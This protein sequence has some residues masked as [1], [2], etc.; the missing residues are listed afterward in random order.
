MEGTLR[1]VGDCLYTYTR[2]LTGYGGFVTGSLLVLPGSA[3]VVDTLCS[4][5]DMEAFIPLIGERPVT[6]VYTHADW[7]HCLGTGALNPIR[8]IAHEL[9]GKRLSERGDDMLAEIERDNPDLVSDASI[10]LPGTTFQDGLTF[11]LM[12]G[13]SS[14]RD[15]GDLNERDREDNDRDDCVSGGPHGSDKVVVEL[16]HLPGHT[17][18]STVCWIPQLGVLIAGDVVEDPFPSVSEP[19][20]TGLWADGLEQWERS[21]ST[22]IPGHGAVSGPELLARNVRYLRGLMGAARRNTPYPWLTPDVSL[23]YLDP[24]TAQIVSKMPASEQAFYRDV[25]KENVRRVISVL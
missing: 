4:P 9:T 11:E 8:V 23:E 21:A 16:V 13:P 1:S 5:R 22:V 25:H 6:V 14:S 2:P 7:D 18:D 12:S 15:G 20:H 24:K 17:E 3:L 10:V 19:L